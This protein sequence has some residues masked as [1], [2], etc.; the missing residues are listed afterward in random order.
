MNNSGRQ[1]GDEGPDG[2]VG[3]AGGAARR[4]A[5]EEVARSVAWGE[6]QASGSWLSGRDGVAEKK[7][8]PWCTSH[9]IPGTGAVG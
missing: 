4:G 9:E 8:R 7:E 1:G 2:A 6:V 3:M 5:A